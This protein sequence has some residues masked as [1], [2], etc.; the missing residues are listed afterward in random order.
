M[1]MT[2]SWFGSLDPP[3]T[4]LWRDRAALECGLP[5]DRHLA[6]P[7]R[8]RSDGAAVLGTVNAKPSRVAAEEATSLGQ[9]RDGF[10]VGDEET[11]FQ[12]EQRN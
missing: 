12:I 10:R 2:A 7:A 4:R 11:A 9:L 6:D 3:N 1:R 5:S 8:L